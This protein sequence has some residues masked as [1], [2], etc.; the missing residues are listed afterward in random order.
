[1]TT[2]STPPSPFPFLNNSIRKYDSL[3]GKYLSAYVDCLR[4]CRRKN[5]LETFL[6]WT[7]TC[8]RDLPALFRASAMLKGG[9]PS[10][11][12]HRDRLLSKNSCLSSL[13]F[14]H[15]VKR[16]TNSA[17]ASVTIHDLSAPP[18]KNDEKAQAQVLE[19]LKTS[20]A[21]F[22]RLN[23]S[24]RDV[25]RSR[26][27]KFSRDSIPEVDALCR[28]FLAMNN[29]KDVHT[30]EHNWSGGA[31]K[32][33]VLNAALEMCQEQFRGLSSSLHAMSAKRRNQSAGKTKKPSKHRSGPHSPSNP[34]GSLPRKDLVGRN[35][36]KHGGENKTVP[37]VVSVP[38]GLSSGDTFQTSVRLGE[39]LKQV[40]LTVPP[41]KPSKL[42]FSLNAPEALSL[43][44]KRL[45][46]DDS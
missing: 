5:K 31:Q 6:K 10:K 30:Q 43:T 14:L 15:V 19:R 7:V 17:I 20:Y 33:A 32:I 37:F 39:V 27:W 40:K 29:H 26:A 34:P 41:G 21:C 18:N 3:R 13:G 35:K 24:V 12:H 11:P 44:E 36:R 1:M 28:A 8:K 2:P 45:R 9:K 42:K 23:S 22:L 4:L 16:Q 25:E 38:A 46:I